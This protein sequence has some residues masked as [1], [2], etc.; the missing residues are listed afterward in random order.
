MAEYEASDAVFGRGLFT[1]LH[2]EH[3]VSPT[4]KAHVAAPPIPVQSF[5]HLE[6]D[7]GGSHLSQPYIFGSDL[8]WQVAQIYGGGMS[9]I[10]EGIIRGCRMGL[11]IYFSVGI[12]PGPDQHP[13]LCQTLFEFQ[14]MIRSGS[15]LLRQVTK[16]TVAVV[17]NNVHK[18]DVRHAHCQPNPQPLQLVGFT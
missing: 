10:L 4:T 17:R 1:L 14:I 16:S 11:A 3:S 13:R 7:Y 8:F 12:V 18:S 5:S 6:L 15:G 9:K 2:T